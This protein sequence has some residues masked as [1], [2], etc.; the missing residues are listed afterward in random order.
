MNHK[1]VFFIEDE[2]DI[3]D[4]Y[5]IQLEKSGFTVESFESGSKALTKINS[6]LEG[7]SAAPQVIVLDLLLPD[8]SGLAILGELRGKPVFD[9]TFIIV[10]T[11]YVSE[12]LQE[13]VKQ[14]DNV[15]YLSKVDTTPSALFDVIKRK[16]LNCGERL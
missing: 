2:K 15:E 12:S 4:L 16:V 14:M 7:R 6:I 11:N 10:F 9:E 5:S 1:K 13:S 3:V 8:I